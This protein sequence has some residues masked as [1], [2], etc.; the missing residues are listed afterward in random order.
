MQP[1]VVHLIRKS[2]CYLSKTDIMFNPHCRHACIL[3]GIEYCYILSKFSVY[4][5][6][7]LKVCAHVAL[8]LYSYSWHLQTGKLWLNMGYCYPFHR[9]CT[10]KNVH[11]EDFNLLTVLSD[12]LLN[13]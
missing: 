9:T 8:R 3:S 11:S 4:I 7:Q 13:T 2:I 5:K 12:R 6:Y 10:S 1:L